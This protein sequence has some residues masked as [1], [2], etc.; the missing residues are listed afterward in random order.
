MN[1]LQVINLMNL[2]KKVK[3]NPKNYGCSSDPSLIFK[4]LE[5]DFSKSRVFCF[6]SFSDVLDPRETSLKEIEEIDLP[7]DCCSFEKVDG[8]PLFVNKRVNL[9]D[10]KPEWMNFDS[11]CLCFLIREFSPKNYRAVSLERFMES[12][13]EGYSLFSWNLDNL[14]E[15]EYSVVG[16]LDKFLH[17]INNSKLGVQSVSDRIKIGKNKEIHKIK[18]VIRVVPKKNFDPSMYSSKI[19]WSHRWEVMGH[20]RK[21]DGIGKDREGEYKVRGFTWIIPHVRGPEDKKIVKKIRVI[22]K[23]KENAIHQTRTD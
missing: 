11:E 18:T 6:E 17:I 2:Y 7:F 12:G 22:P 21:I 15:D 8:S 20:W 1:T 4:H 16:V 10:D 19:D 13:K 23:E 3:L 9:T 5:D 14:N